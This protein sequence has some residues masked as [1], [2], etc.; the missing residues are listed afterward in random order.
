MPSSYGGVS[1]EFSLYSVKQRRGVAALFTLLARGPKQ[2]TSS[3]E[4]YQFI[5]G[6]LFAT[7]VHRPAAK[8]I[9][10]FCGP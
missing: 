2:A 5:G 7:H 10:Q 9:M 3:N 4:L 8:L 6:Q 1:D